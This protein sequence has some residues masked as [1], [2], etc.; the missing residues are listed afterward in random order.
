MTRR[1]IKGKLVT[2]AV[3]AVILI[4]IMATGAAVIWIRA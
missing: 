3:V 4:V 1:D 2:L